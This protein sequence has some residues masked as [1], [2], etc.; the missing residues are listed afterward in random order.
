VTTARGVRPGVSIKGYTAVLLAIL[1]L[2][3]TGCEGSRATASAS[4]PASASALSGAARA[5]GGATEARAPGGA[6]AGAR[7]PATLAGL[8]YLEVRTGGAAEGERL[9]LV[10]ALHGLGDEASQFAHLFRGMSLKTRVIVPD[11]PLPQGGGHSWFPTEDRGSEAWAAGIR[12]A[13][14]Q[15][16]AAMKEA[17]EAFPT[18]GRPFV[19]GF[20]QGGML[21][22]TMAVHEPA[23]VA[24]SFPLG[25]WL[26]PPLWPTAKAAGVSYP[27][28][29]ALHGEADE[30]LPIGPT[31]E[32][33]A[34][35]VSLGFPAELRGF[36]GVRHTVSG[37]MRHELE[38][39]LAAAID[40]NRGAK[41]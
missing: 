8:H 30:R 23:A 31:R 1:A 22:F 39:L 21:S 29:V 13:A 18:E 37:E 20:S 10:F 28:I 25:G 5:P 41:R 19:T 14:G 11:G 2:P 6:Q 9:P 24:A 27:R 36:A 35:L 12:R 7:A 3:A 38:G 40:E 17:S 4:A 32:G 34:R 16:A 15:I 26:P 33:V